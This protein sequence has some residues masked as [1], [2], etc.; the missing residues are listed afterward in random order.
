[1]SLLLHSRL[2]HWCPVA[3]SW[4]YHLFNLFPPAPPSSSSPL[5]LNLWAYLYPGDSKE[6]I[7]APQTS[8][9]RD[10]SEHESDKAWSIWSPLASSPFLWQLQIR[11]ASTT[12]NSWKTTRQQLHRAS[13]DKLIFQCGEDSLQL[14]QIWGILD[15]AWAWIHRLEVLFCSVKYRKTLIH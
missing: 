4:H 8:L 14:Q 15:A 9:E 11:K 2:S 1:M 3:A 10:N 12:G 7:K 13:D 6:P 5:L